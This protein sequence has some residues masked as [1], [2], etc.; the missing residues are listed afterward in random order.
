MDIV[1]LGGALDPSK[2]ISV[3][4]R[5]SDNREKCSNLNISANWKPNTKKI[6]GMTH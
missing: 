3:F 4:M 5:V 6:E 2:Q 1:K